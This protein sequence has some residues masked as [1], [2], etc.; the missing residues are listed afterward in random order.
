MVQRSRGIQSGLP[1]HNQSLPDFNPSVKSIQK[2]RPPFRKLDVHKLITNQS[3][4]GTKWNTF[5]DEARRVLNFIY[6][7]AVVREKNT[8]YTFLR[9]GEKWEQMKEI[10][11]KNAGLK[12]S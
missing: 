11:I 6:D 1:R 10:F 3:E 2:Q 12:M 5:W 4:F 9:S 7:Q 8:F